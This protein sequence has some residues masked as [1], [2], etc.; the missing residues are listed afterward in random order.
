MHTY[1]TVILLIQTYG[2]VK[3]ERGSCNL[4]FS[5]P[6]IKMLLLLSYFIAFG[7]TTLVNFS[8]VISEADGFYYDLLKYFECNLF[9]SNP[10]CEEYRQKFEKHLKPGLNAVTFIM[11]GLP[12]AHLLF[13]VQAHDVKQLM[14]KMMTWCHAKGICA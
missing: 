2:L 13:A 10:R 11:L 3:N 7:V 14:K 6:E 8:I 1:N 4:Y 12:W 9:G 5:V